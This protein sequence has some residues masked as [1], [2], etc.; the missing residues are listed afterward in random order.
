MEL[1]AGARGAAQ[2]DGPG[3]SLVASRSLFL[4]LRAAF[5]P[6]SSYGHVQ[7]GWGENV[8]A[9]VMFVCLGSLLGSC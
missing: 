6:N 4:P 3:L 8:I 1:I 7:P 2:W 9:G 5:T